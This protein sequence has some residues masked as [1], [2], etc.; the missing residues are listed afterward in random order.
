M[1]AEVRVRAGAAWGSYA[2]LRR[3]RDLSFD[4]KYGD[5]PAL[6]GLT[7]PTSDA[8]ALGLG[9]QSVIEVC[10]DGKTIYDSW[11]SID[12]TSGTSV[13]DDERWT[14]YS[15]RGI[16]SW[17]SDARVYPSAWPSTVP[18]DHS[19]VN[20][21]PGTIIRTLVARAQERGALLWLD[22]SSFTGTT[23]TDARPWDAVWSGAYSAG[24]D[25]LQVLTSLATAGLCSWRMQGMSLQLFNLGG[26]VTLWTPEQV[27]FRAGRDIL[28]QTSNTDST[29]WADTVLIVGDQ[30]QAV[31]RTN[32]TATSQIGRR[33][34]LYVSQSGITDNPTLAMLGD[35]YL[36]LQAHLKEEETLGTPDTVQPWFAF[37]AGDWVWEDRDGALLNRQVK[38]ISGG[39]QDENNLKVGL[40]LGDI[41]DSQDVK[42]QRLLDAILGGGTGGLP[43]P[44]VTDKVAPGPPSGIVVN[45]IPYRD[46]NGHDFEQVTVSWQA[47]TINVDG[48]VC[49]DI[50]HY[51]V[52]WTIVPDS[53]LYI[54]PGAATAKPLVVGGR[55][56]IPR[57]VITVGGGCNIL[58]SVVAAHVD[59]PTPVVTGNS[60]V[61]ESL[62]SW[63]FPTTDPVDNTDTWTIT[64]T[65]PI[66]N[67]DSWNFG[68]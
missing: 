48:S 57:P 4:T 49:N 22:V 39:A 13:A 30:N 16:V 3:Y 31:E 62:E 51:D 58:A 32:P 6:G 43:N 52:E 19:F 2:I 61:T 68:V 64:A 5:L 56:T 27:T 66:D 14:T 17:L 53:G 10:P 36:S 26:Y 38:Q 67:T 1:F 35:K 28:E 60:V 24:T 29:S 34:E 63:T 50:D 44:N 9:N 33:R 59:I 55:A 15:G 23:S 45:V 8:L 54:P 7:V 46:A 12:G 20:A 42:T 40:T 47:P 41:L 21:T 65:D 11:Y 37:H 18:A 25:Y